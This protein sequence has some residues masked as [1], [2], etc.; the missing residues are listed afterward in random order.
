MIDVDK[1]VGWLIPS[2]EKSLSSLPLSVAGIECLKS[3]RSVPLMK[4]LE[5]HSPLYDGMDGKQQFPLSCWMQQSL[6]SIP[7]HI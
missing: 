2:D 7:H 4:L 1:M 3:V 5:E 6:S